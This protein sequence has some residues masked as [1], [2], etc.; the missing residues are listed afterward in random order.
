VLGQKGGTAEPDP[1]NAR[2]PPA[3]V[4]AKAD[5]AGR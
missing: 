5:G 2:K 1:N 3:P 4:L